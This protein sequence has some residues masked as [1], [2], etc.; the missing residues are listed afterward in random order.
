MSTHSNSE[1]SSVEKKGS[2]KKRVKGRDQRESRGTDRE[3]ESPE[4]EEEPGRNSPQ[5]LHLIACA[6]ITSAQ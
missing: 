6:L 4:A 5:Y 3:S 2:G 1:K